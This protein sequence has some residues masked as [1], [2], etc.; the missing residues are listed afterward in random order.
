MRN[1]QI[2]IQIDATLSLTIREYY[3][4]IR[5]LDDLSSLEVT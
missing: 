2:D 1:L 3:L 4:L 5:S